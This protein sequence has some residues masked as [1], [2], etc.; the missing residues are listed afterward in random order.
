ME[1]FYI[2]GSCRNEWISNI[3]DIYP[4]SITQYHFLE[5]YGEIKFFTETLPLNEQSPPYPFMNWVFNLCA[6]TKAHRDSGDKKWCVTFTLGNCIGGQLAL[7]KLGLVFE[8]TLGD[9]I[10]F[11]SYNQTHFNLHITGI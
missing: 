11:Q 2:K 10:T 6:C 5:T 7:Y 4:I 9:M 3:W 1:T 8:C